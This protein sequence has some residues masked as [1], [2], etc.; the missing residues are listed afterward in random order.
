MKKIDIAMTFYFEWIDELS[1]LEKT[2]AFD[3]ICDLAEYSKNGIRKKY[4]D[5]A[6]E[7]LFSMMARQID[8]D[9]EKYQSK[10]SRNSAN[11]S[12]RWSDKQTDANGC[13]RIVSHKS[14]ANNA[15]KDEYEDEEEYEDENK[16]K[17]I[18]HIAQSD[19]KNP[20]TLETK[21]IIT[22]TLH[23]NSEYAVVE[24]QLKEWQEL[25]PDVDIMQ[26][27]RNMKGWLNA[28]PTKRKTRRGICKFI[29]SWLTREQKKEM[30]KRVT[31]GTN[32]EPDTRT[33][34][35]YGIPIL[36]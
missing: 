10:C 20:S 23:D 3:M 22:L 36:R 27:L 26:E 28:N 12:K 8:R 13:D 4:D 29:N 16:N 18:K 7:F 1:K 33:V 35:K 14:H 15:Y 31:N 30:E 11:A 34:D 9:K 2:E 25:Y 5:R 6:L 24:Y 21:P 32:N 17:N 19:L